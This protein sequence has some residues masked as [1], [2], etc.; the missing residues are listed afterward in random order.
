MKK[1]LILLLFLVGCAQK[2]K[3]EPLYI[4]GPVKYVLRSDIEN[5]ATVNNMSYQQAK[6]EYSTIY[7][8]QLL[9]QR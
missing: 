1:F 3:I 5:F 6:K 7:T 4:S 9:D 8:F 2:E